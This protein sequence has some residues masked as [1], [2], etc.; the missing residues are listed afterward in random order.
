MGSGIEGSCTWKNPSFSHAHRI[1]SITLVLLGPSGRADPLLECS[2]SKRSQITWEVIL[3]H[4][5]YILHLKIVFS[6]A[7]QG[8]NKIILR[9]K[10][11]F[12]F[13]PFF[14]NIL[15]EVRFHPCQPVFSQNPRVLGC[16]SGI[17]FEY[18]YQKLYP[19]FSYIFIE[20]SPN[21]LEFMA[22]CSSI[23]GQ[24]FNHGLVKPPK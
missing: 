9:P 18:S 20:I 3:R 10:R 1:S 23:S 21:P 11:V 19:F 16:I 4:N 13:L 24:C 6:T 14:K 2:W 7:H 17:G 12:K 15:C 22:T 5:I 8:F